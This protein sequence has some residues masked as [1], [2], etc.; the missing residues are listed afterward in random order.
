MQ[1]QLEAGARGSDEIHEGMTVAMEDFK[2]Y[3]TA[4]FQMEGYTVTFDFNGQNQ[5]GNTPLLGPKPET[6]K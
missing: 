6:S 3:F 4:I 1:A 2:R 5:L